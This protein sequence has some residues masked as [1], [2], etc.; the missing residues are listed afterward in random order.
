MPG[1]RTTL[2][3][4]VVAIGV[5]WSG[6]TFAVAVPD[7]VEHP[8]RFVRIAAFSWSKARI[9]DMEASLTLESALPFAL[10]EIEVECTHYA[11]SGIE[12]ASARRTIHT[13]LPAGGRIEVRELDMGLIHAQAASSGC[14]VVSV[15]PA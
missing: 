8:E 10:Q 1:P 11:H 13:V 14:Q 7:Q 4:C 6:A 2:A 15:A 9:E 3:T 12:L 5:L